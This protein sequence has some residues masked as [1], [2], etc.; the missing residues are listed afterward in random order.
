M[1]GDEQRFYNDKNIGYLH[2]FPTNCRPT[3]ARRGERFYTSINCNGQ[4]VTDCEASLA[5]DAIKKL[6]QVKEQNNLG[7]VLH[8][9]LRIQH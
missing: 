9:L 5:M 2:L 8:Q 4:W 3:L 6:T 7:I 1:V